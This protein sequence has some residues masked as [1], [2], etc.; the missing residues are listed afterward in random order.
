M[1]FM[2]PLVPKSIFWENHTASSQS[3]SFCGRF[4]SSQYCFSRCAENA[5]R[6]FFDSSAIFS[7]SY[8]YCG[9]YPPL[10]GTPVIMVTG[11][12]PMELEDAG[13]PKE[14]TVLP[15]PVDFRRLAEE[16]AKIA[17]KLGG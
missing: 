15:K 11:A 17:S 12:T 5:R 8:R 14:V 16:I 2:S 6:K 10:A 13:I 3:R 1:S 9:P 4:R 7:P